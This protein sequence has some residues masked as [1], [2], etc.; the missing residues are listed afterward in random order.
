MSSP[1]RGEAPPDSSDKDSTE[2]VV[3]QLR[4][5]D[6]E[7]IRS[8]KIDPADTE[9]YLLA[10]GVSLIDPDFLEFE[11]RTEQE[12]AELEDFTRLL[13]STLTHTG[14]SD[15]GSVTSEN[16]KNIDQELLG[17]LDPYNAESLFFEVA[18]K[19]H[20]RLGPYEPVTWRRIL[21]QATPK[22]R[23][24]L[25]LDNLQLEQRLRAF[26]YLI[27]LGIDANEISDMVKS[28]AEA[29]VA[30]PSK[31]QNVNRMA[32][33]FQEEPLLVGLVKGLQKRAK[34]REK[35]GEPPIGAERAVRMGQII[36]R[37][38]SER[39]E[40][41]RKKQDELPFGDERKWDTIDYDVYRK[42]R[43]RIKVSLAISDLIRAEMR[44]ETVE[45]FLDEL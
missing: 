28:S 25:D 42:M 39:L 45:E 35:L 36:L 10:N 40:D 38:Q 15:P 3:E 17:Q 41:R 37:L 43:G 7:L 6:R 2:N 31:R 44:T 30:A 19:V 23:P 22:D 18:Q 29:G 13:R 34:R 27:S 20:L 11:A 21:E 1:D 33:F 16:V 8:G 4:R 12:Q 5:Y 14:L 24:V 9:D 26:S 32:Y